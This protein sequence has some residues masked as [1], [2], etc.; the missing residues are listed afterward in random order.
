[1]K[2]YLRIKVHGL[3]Q[4]KVVM[5]KKITQRQLMHHHLIL[6]DTNLTARPEHHSYAY[7]EIILVII[8]WI[9][10]YDI[11]VLEAFSFVK[12]NVRNMLN[13]FVV[14]IFAMRSLSSTFFA[15]NF[16]ICSH[17]LKNKQNYDILFAFFFL[18]ILKLKTNFKN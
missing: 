16:D 3:M 9:H 7:N 18:L 14:I 15:T 6:R 4:R 11:I 1:M 8:K 5:K 2:N 13:F 17:G 10:W 12:T